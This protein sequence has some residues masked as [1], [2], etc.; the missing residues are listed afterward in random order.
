M[1]LSTKQKAFAMIDVILGAALFALVATF[2]VPAYLYGQE[3]IMIDGKR[4]QAINYAESGLE[5]L[6]NIRD[7]NF[8][9]ISPGTYGLATTSSG[10]V[11]SGSSDTRDEFTR[12]IIIE[13][14]D[15]ERLIAKANITWKQNSQRDGDIT[16]ETRLNNF[17]KE[18]ETE[19]EGNASYSINIDNDWLTGYCATVTISS[20]STTPIEWNVNIDLS[21]SP[22]QAIPYNIWNA[23][24]TF[25]DPILQASGLDFNKTVSLGN[26]AQFGYCANRPSLPI[27]IIAS[28]SNP[29]D[30]GSKAGP[31]TIISPPSGLMSGDLVIIAASYRGAA[32]INMAA[33]GGQNWNAFDQMANGN[34]LR[35]RIFFTVFNG[36]WSGNP[37]V[38]IGSGNL[39]LS[40]VMH[41]FRNTDPYNPIDVWQNS[42]TFNSPGNPRNVQIDSFNTSSNGAMVLAF[43][44]TADDNSWALQSLDWSNIELAQYRNRQGSDSSISSAYKSLETPGPSGDV[45]N[46]QTANGGDAG[47]WH[48]FSIRRR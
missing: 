47:N 32:N 28:A 38:S 29:A 1:V 26:S 7:N 18:Q 15:S 16:L 9:E 39:G 10:W 6:R 34:V 41:V 45:I 33:T 11:L 5:A 46:R 43:W 31:T 19:G 23:N 2:A 12:K 42:G 27:S 8:Y 20:T 25:N 13:S 3:A 22:Y 35:S 37:S 21:Q 36:T 17:Y 40:A 44:F 4:Q 48:V 14:L 24:W 30:N